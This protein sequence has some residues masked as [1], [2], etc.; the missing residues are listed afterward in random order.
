MKSNGESFGEE[1]HQNVP[2]R[3]A[4]AHFHDLVIHLLELCSLT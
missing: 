3:H 1:L 4:A 2:L